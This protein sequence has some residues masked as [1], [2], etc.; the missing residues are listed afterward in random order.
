M[1]KMYSD[2][3]QDMF[4]LN[5][6]NFKKDGYFVDVGSHNPILSNNTYALEENGWNGICIEIE[7]RFNQDYQDKRKATL[8]NQDA[9][10]ISYI[11]LFK[12][13]NSPRQI[14]YLSLDIDAL[15]I[16]V[17]KILPL[18]E[19]EFKVITI[20]H[21]AYLFGN[22]YRKPQRKLLESKGYELLCANVFVEQENFKRKRCAFEDWW[23]KPEFFDPIEVARIRSK[24]SYP[25]KILAKFHS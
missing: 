6:F 13:E 21:D 8:V 22:K 1:K 11:D 23:I 19:Y 10:T 3:L 16:D 15:S 20:E 2:A 7:N 24:K 18:D 17:L 5:M 12:S 9:T 25:S 4:V 14:D